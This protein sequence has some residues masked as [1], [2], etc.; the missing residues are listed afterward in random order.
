[1][2]SAISMGLTWLCPTRIP[3]YPHR[4]CGTALSEGVL[5]VTYA[6]VGPVGQDAYHV[7][8]QGVVVRFSDVEEVFGEG[9]QRVLFAGGNRL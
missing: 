9:A 2:L 6:D 5:D 4:D 8:P 7:E 1:M 3:C